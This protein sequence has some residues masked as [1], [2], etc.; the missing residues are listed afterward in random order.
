MRV[1]VCEFVTGGGL[2]GA[3]LPASLAR[4]GDMMLQSLVKDLA[5]LPD[6]TVVVTR[7]GRLPVQSA[8]TTGRYS[9]RAPR[10]AWTTAPDLRSMTGMIFM[11]AALARSRL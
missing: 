3:V 6:I 5:D 9:S 10:R 2:A 1:L 8:E 4:E 11:G 7:D